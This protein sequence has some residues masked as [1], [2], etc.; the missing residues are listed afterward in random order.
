MKGIPNV[1]P[2]SCHHA[3]K[4]WLKAWVGEKTKNN[5]GVEN[6]PLSTFIKEKEPLI[7]GTPPTKDNKS[8]GDQEGRRLAPEPESWWQLLLV[9]ESARLLWTSQ[10]AHATEREWSLEGGWLALWKSGPY[11]RHQYCRQCGHTQRIPVTPW[12]MAD[13]FVL[14]LAVCIWFWRGLVSSVLDLWKRWM[15]VTSSPLLSPLFRYCFQPAFLSSLYFN[16]LRIIFGPVLSGEGGSADDWRCSLDTSNIPQLPPV[17]P[18]NNP[19]T[20]CIGK[21]IS[22]AS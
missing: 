1:L 20:N 21:C 5:I 2:Y 8:N 12:R 18:K 17:T 10:A 13:I 3:L 16:N 19:Y 15:D 9:L 14:F 22:F 4:A 7:P 11:R 6:Q